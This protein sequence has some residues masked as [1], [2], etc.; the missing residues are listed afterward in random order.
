[1]L[2]DKKPAKDYAKELRSSRHARGAR[3]N[4]DL[5]APGVLD[6]QLSHL[7][8]VM[9]ESCLARDPGLARPASVI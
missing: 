3:K 7:A 8:S 4:D 1:M 9:L 5:L 2:F 6:P